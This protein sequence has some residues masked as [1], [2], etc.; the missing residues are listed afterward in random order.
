MWTGKRNNLCVSC[1]MHPVEDLA[2]CGIHNYKV[3]DKSSIPWWLLNFKRIGQYN[4]ADIVTL[5]KIMKFCAITGT[6]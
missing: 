3:K 4:S 2:T 1:Y 5:R 6:V